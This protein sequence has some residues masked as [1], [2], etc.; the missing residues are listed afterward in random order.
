[1]WDAKTCWS[2]AKWRI[3]KRGSATIRS[4]AVVLALHVWVTVHR[5]M[6]ERDVAALTLAACWP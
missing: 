4:K 2:T 5:I 1:V 3:V 6:P